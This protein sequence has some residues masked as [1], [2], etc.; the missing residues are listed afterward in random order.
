MLLHSIEVHAA[1]VKLRRLHSIIKAG[2]KP[3]GKGSKFSG[4][5]GSAAH[6][7]FIF[8]RAKLGHSFSKGDHVT[9]K[10]NPVQ[11]VEIYEDY[12]PHVEW[13]GLCP[14]F[15]EV[16]DGNEKQLIVLVHPSQLRRKR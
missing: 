13:D 3:I 14:K 1:P 9:L 15:V 7:E 6:K 10:R 11:I 16:W 8:E 12:G 5:S 2:G 4:V